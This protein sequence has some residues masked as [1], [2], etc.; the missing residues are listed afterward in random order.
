VTYCPFGEQ[1]LKLTSQ[2]P[3]NLH[4]IFL[5]YGRK[6][7]IIRT[8]FVLGLDGWDISYQPGTGQSRQSW[9]FLFTLNIALLLAETMHPYG[10]GRVFTFGASVDQF[11]RTSAVRKMKY[12]YSRSSL[13]DF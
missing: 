2:P 5:H 13:A 12:Q 10:Y 8:K 7:K 6:E 1:S 9:I 4:S 3:S 11:D